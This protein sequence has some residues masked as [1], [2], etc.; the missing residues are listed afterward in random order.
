[1]TVVHVHGADTATARRRLQMLGAAISAATRVTVTHRMLHSADGRPVSV[2]E[3][4]KDETHTH[5]LGYYLQLKSGELRPLH[6][7]KPP[8]QV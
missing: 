6:F 8:L 4:T 1:V 5:A 3:V 7:P 2:R